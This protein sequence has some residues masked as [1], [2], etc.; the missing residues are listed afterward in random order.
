MLSFISSLSPQPKAPSAMHSAQKKHTAV[1][2]QG[3]SGAFSTLKQL[4]KTGLEELEA[5]KLNIMLA[6]TGDFPYHVGKL[7]NGR[8][9]VVSNQ[10]RLFL[11]LPGKL[12]ELPV[13]ESFRTRCIGN[14][15]RVIQSAG[16]LRVTLENTNGI[17][18][19]K[20]STLD[21]ESNTRK[22]LTVVRPGKPLAN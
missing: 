1:N 3:E 6:E 19:A 21:L 13:K 22:E 15:K 10:D 5:R 11:G 2:F 14:Q 12:T 18:T 17:R 16:G 7:T 20:L 9:F 4:T 8:V